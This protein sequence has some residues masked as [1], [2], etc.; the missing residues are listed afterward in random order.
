M[1]AAGLLAGGRYAAADWPVARHDPQRTGTATGTSNIDLPIPYWRYYL[2]G[3][4]G[5]ANLLT[6]DID[7]DGRAEFIVVTGGRAVTKQTSDFTVWATKPIGLTSLEGLV[8]LDGDGALELVVRST[9]RVFVLSA[10]TGAVLW[11]QPE[12]EMG[13]IRGVR[14]GDLTGDGRPDLVIGECGCCTVRTDTPGVVYSFASGFNPVAPLW[15]FPISSCG[16]TERSLSLV[17]VDGLPGDEVI[18]GGFDSLSVVNGTTGQVLASTDPLGNRIDRS[19]CMGVDLDG[20]AGDEIICILNDRLPPGIDQRKAFVLRY[21]PEAS[22]RLE[23]VWSLILAPDLDGDLS[24]VD[25]VADLDGDGKLEI[26]ISAKDETGTWTTRILAAEDGT[27]I[28]ALSGQIAR[29]RVASLPGGSTVLLTAEG[30]D[31]VGWQVARGASPPARSLWRVPDT[32]VLTVDD[33][34]RKARGGLFTR[35]LEV[36]VQGDGRAD[37]LGQRLVGASRLTAY[38]TDL[39]AVNPI[40]VLDAPTGFDFVGAWPVVAPAAGIL[41]VLQNDGAL[42]LVDEN[43]VAVTSGDDVLGSGL[44]FGGY[45]L[46]G[47]WRQ[48]QSTVVAGRLSATATADSVI[49]RDSRGSLIALDPSLSSFASPPRPQWTAAESFS[50]VIVD[51]LIGGT[52][53]GIACLALQ[54]PV[55]PDP[56]YELN[57]L[58]ANGTVEWSVNIPRVPFNDVLPAVL[59]DDGVPD[60]VFEWG[61]PSNTSVS[62]RGISGA[63]GSTLWDSAP[64]DAGNGRQPAG[65]AIGRWNADASSDIVYQARSTRVVSGVDGVELANSGPGYAYYQPTLSDISGTGELE[66]VLH[67]STA[68]AQMLD[69]SLQTVLWTSAHDDK[70]KPYGALVRCA[71][72]DRTVLVEGSELN[73]SRLKFSTLSGAN[74]REERA[75]VLAGGTVFADELEAQQD[76]RLLGSLGSVATHRDLRGTGTPLALVGSDDGWLY[77]LDPC[78]GTLA[79]SYEFGAPVGSPIFADTDGDGRDEILV[80]VA[81]GYLYNLRQLVIAAPS[82]VWD[83]DPTQGIVDRDVDTISTLS[84]ISARWRDVTGTLSYELAVVTSDGDFLTSPAWQDQGNVTQ[85]TVTGLSLTVGRAYFV[86]V[87]AIGPDG[88]SV[89]TMSDGIVVLPGRDDAGSDGGLG[90]SRNGGC[91]CNGGSAHP[92]ALSILFFVCMGRLLLRRRPRSAHL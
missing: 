50:P 52:E 67:G 56:S 31:V 79:L 18:V 11:A 13:T 32:T 2:G 71:G 46:E 14:L 86:S 5:R 66:V 48:L 38:S 29:G 25:P 85:A 3:T 90:G 44:R 22:S 39:A 6:A 43:L 75:V 28:A 4:I 60:L 73:P 34:A 33:R 80:S 59:D 30:A 47:G 53:P 84:E 62:F 57:A 8:D 27:E 63:N 70:P 41:A 77:G 17:N 83:I 16:G 40:A 10:L 49:A 89:D 72:T 1:V 23:V 87:R 82:Y 37:L 9:S 92:G 54:Q 35:V 26:V 78:T 61:D 55:T 7:G 21:D 15:V 69:H 42:R 91:G 68:A 51:K 65:F 64:I 58:R 36:D 45:Y 12:G 81:D 24:W 76:G 19:E 88:R 20:I 74:F